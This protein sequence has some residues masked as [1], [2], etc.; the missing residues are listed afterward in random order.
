MSFKP[1]VKVDNK[2]SD[3]AQRF[4]TREEAD[5]AARDIMSRWMLVTDTSVEETTDPVNFQ[6]KDNVISML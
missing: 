3:N 2:F 1:L 5:Q 4:E 6:I